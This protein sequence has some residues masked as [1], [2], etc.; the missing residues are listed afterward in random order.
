VD[1]ETGL[2]DDSF[3]R[4]GCVI[5]H[6]QDFEAL[7]AGK[8]DVGARVPVVMHLVVS[9]LAQGCYQ[10]SANQQVEGVVDRC[11][12]K[13]GM[14]GLEVI[15]DLLRGRVAVRLNQ[16]FIDRLALRSVAKPRPKD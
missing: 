4:I 7:G 8:V 16:V 14:T 10:T 12:R 5:R 1:I 9:D 11:Q 15:V 6:V 13:A 2:F 3:D